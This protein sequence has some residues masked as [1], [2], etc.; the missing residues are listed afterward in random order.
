LKQRRTV[1]ELN[2]GV[3]AALTMSDFLAI[4]I[5]IFA[6]E[7]SVGSLH[8]PLGLGYGLPSRGPLS[9]SFLRSAQDLLRKR[10]SCEARAL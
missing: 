2:F 9:R 10:A 5:A 6:W 7:E 4:D 8:P 3:R 1:R